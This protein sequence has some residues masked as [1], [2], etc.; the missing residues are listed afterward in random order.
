M[1]FLLWR[2]R[3]Q[4]RRS[5]ESHVAGT[6]GRT[7][8]ASVSF[9]EYRALFERNP[10]PM[11]I[12]DPANLKI[13]DVNDAA[14]SCYGYEKEE[15]LSLGIDALRPAEERERLKKFVC[16]LSQETPSRSGPWKHRCKG[17]R[18][19]DAE[20]LSV[21]LSYRQRPARLVLVRDVSVELKERRQLDHLSKAYELLAHLRF[22]SS[23]VTDETAYLTEICRVAVEGGP[24]VL[25][26][27]GYARDDSARTIEPVAVAGTSADYLTEIAVSWDESRPEGR[28]PAG[29]AVREGHVVHVPDID[30]CV[31]FVPWRDR[32]RSHEFRSCSFFP[33]S[34]PRLRGVMC[35]YSTERQPYDEFRFSLL[36]KIV[37]EL[38]TGIVHIRTGRNLQEL[39]AAVKRLALLASQGD[40]RVTVKNV[41]RVAVETLQADFGVVLRHAPNSQRATLL[42]TWESPGT[43]LGYACVPDEDL[44]ARLLKNVPLVFYGTNE[45]VSHPT[46]GYQV[47]DRFW[48]HKPLL[49][50]SG[51]ALLGFLVLC[52]AVRPE[53]T[54]TLVSGLELFASRISAEIVRHDLERRET[55]T[56][57]LLEQVGS[58]VVA[59]D[60]E[61]RIVLW[62]NGATTICGWS[63][64]EVMNKSV[65]LLFS[66]SPVLRGLMTAVD[67]EGR[68]H[69]RVPVLTKSGDE[70]VIDLNV[71]VVTAL[72]DES[73]LTVA[74]GTDVTTQARLEEQL[75]HAERLEVVGQLTGGIAH[76]FNNYL[77]VILGNTDLLIGENPRAENVHEL[78]LEIRQAARHGA[79]LTKHLL[80]FARRQPLNP[81]VLNINAFLSSS[82]K[83]IRQTLSSDIDLE[84]IQ[85]AGLWDVVIDPVQLEAALL[86]LCLNARDAMPMGG[87]LTI[88]STNVWIDRNYADQ[89]IDVQPGQYVLLAVSDTGTGVRPEHLPKIFEPFFTTKGPGK[90][91]GLGLSMVYGFIKQSQGHIKVY[92]ELNRGTT[93]KIYLPRSGP[94][95]Q[96]RPQLHASARPL[97]LK[98]TILVVE[99]NPMIRRFVSLQ[100]NE[101]GYRVLE[102][103][104]AEEALELAR[105]A[106]TID[107]LFVDIVMPGGMN[108]K[109]LAEVLRRRIPGLR[110]LYTSGYTENAIVHQ[111]KL[112]PGTHLLNKPYTRADLLRMIR[113][114]LTE[115]SGD[116]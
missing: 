99:D 79:E 4:E 81:S 7:S 14:L 75:H 65:E 69:G 70:K 10:E 57:Y 31:D 29:R 25:C 36:E 112:D 1:A 77:T 74:I 72:D 45:L 11:L 19:F 89:Y 95:D 67:S 73:P 116:E 49:D 18:V 32:A 16:T 40:V 46:P 38:A 54:D 105:D 26:W 102:A 96:S 8:G 111:G 100:L 47:K 115:P 21:G 27:I 5:R 113:A 59:W 92:S 86:N 43:R 53:S 61:K 9:D 37:R 78:A 68:W 56:A 24:Y 3:T 85:G 44:L 93:F 76:D 97:P 64:D 2:R 22:L 84:I 48:I 15:F 42:A 60:H 20:I 23:S 13:L 62:N 52:Y 109:Q 6:G 87:Q 12:Y 88:E 63:K 98:A 30:Q 50:P 33:F 51:D 104:D 107:L 106:T 90:G 41:L 91:T 34:A 17:D 28:G 103:S 35:L 101:L 55:R 83:L 108:G 114:V 80:A 110:V 66:D 58:A 39:D 71:H 82:E 94:A